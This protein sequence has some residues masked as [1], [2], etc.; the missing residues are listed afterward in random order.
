MIN[1]LVNLHSISTKQALP[2]RPAKATSTRGR[3]SL[4]DGTWC[5]QFLKSY[6]RNV[7]MQ[8]ILTLANH[9]PSCQIVLSYFW[10]YFFWNSENPFI[11]LM[12]GIDLE[13]QEA[14]CSS[15]AEL[16]L[17]H[18]SVLSV[19]L[20]RDSVWVFISSHLWYRNNLQTSIPR[21]LYPLVFVC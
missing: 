19:L 1:I 9:S 10:I 7:M 16:V 4:G 13:S 3:K 14:S 2:P 18:H 21:W 8:F 5:S 11:P 12:F 20:A 6:L 17:K 15:I